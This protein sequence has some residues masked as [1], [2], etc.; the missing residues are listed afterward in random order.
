VLSFF[1][2]VD[3]TTAGSFEGAAGNRLREAYADWWQRQA[4]ILTADERRWKAGKAKLAFSIGCTS[5]QV[6]KEHLNAHCYERV[7]GM[8]LR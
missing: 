7:N 8:I 5:R 4:R 2:K 6:Q 3:R 1:V